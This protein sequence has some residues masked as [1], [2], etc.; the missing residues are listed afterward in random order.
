MLGKCLDDR[1]DIGKSRSQRFEQQFTL[2]R[3]RNAAGG[4]VKQPQAK[5]F[6]QRRDRMADGG[7]R[8]GQFGRGLAEA[9]AFGNGGENGQLGELHTV[10]CSK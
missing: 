6:L 9:A 5:A 7:R 3:R 8:D 10:H 4:A 2:L 1:I